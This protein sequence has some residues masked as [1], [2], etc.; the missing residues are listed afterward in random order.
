MTG[1]KDAV[2]QLPNRTSDRGRRQ[3]EAPVGMCDPSDAQPKQAACWS[4]TPHS[5]NRQSSRLWSA[6][7]RAV[8]QRNIAVFQRN[9]EEADR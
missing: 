3:R 6:I 8:F 2:E 7:Q 1:V 9:I 5:C 4:L